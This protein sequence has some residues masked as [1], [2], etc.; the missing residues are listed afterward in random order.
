[1]SDTGGVYAYSTKMELREWHYLRQNSDENTSLPDH[2]Q[3]D[4]ACELLKNYNGDLDKEISDR[5][6]LAN[7]LHEFRK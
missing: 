2:P 3:V 1:M 7:L 4:E 5:G 6:R